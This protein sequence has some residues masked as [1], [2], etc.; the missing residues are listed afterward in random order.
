MRISICDDSRVM[1][2][3]E[4][5]SIRKIRTTDEIKCYDN[6]TKLM[7]DISVYRPEVVFF[8]I[9]LNQDK[10]GIDYAVK[11]NEVLPEALIVF[12]SQYAEYAVDAH[13]ADHC[14]YILKDN[15]EKQ[16]EDVFKRIESKILGHKKSMEGIYITALHAKEKIFLYLQDII[17]ISTNQRH[18]EI[19]TTNG[20]YVTNNKLDDFIKELGECDIVRCHQSFAINLHNI[21]NYSRESVIMKNGEYVPISRKYITSVR[22]AFVR[23]AEKRM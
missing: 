10:S 5:K 19:H 4:E 3:R 6:P 13:R 20:I 14:Y 18:M 7:A 8:D 1:L 15:L 9:D 17:Y 21:E 12:V 23:Y 2:A 16:I 22:E 11:V